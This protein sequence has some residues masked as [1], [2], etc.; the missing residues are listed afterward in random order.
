MIGILIYLLGVFIT[1]FS[2]RSA[3]WSKGAYTV[4]DKIGAISYSL[5]SWI[6]II[7]AISSRF[8]S[9][10]GLKRPVKW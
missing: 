8:I 9:D 5:L 4:G 10:E 2:V 3:Y 1:Y 6:S 7:V